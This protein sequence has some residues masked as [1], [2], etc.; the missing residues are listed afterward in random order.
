MLFSLRHAILTI[1]ITGG[2]AMPGKITKK[3]QEI[4]EYIKDQILKK[5]YPPT[6]REICETVHLKSTSSVRVFD[7]HIP[8]KPCQAYF[9]TSN[10]ILCIAY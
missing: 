9:F 1:S 3:Q 7:T 8:E 2:T 10:L 5:G 6:V 4:L